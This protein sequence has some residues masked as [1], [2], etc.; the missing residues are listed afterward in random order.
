M[1][2]KN[3]ALTE[4]SPLWVLTIVIGSVLVTLDALALGIRLRARS[5]QSLSLCFNDYAVLLAWVCRVVRS[6][7]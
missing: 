2:P 6:S 5:L 4:K 1:D 7:S 3:P